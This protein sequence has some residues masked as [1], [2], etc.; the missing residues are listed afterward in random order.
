MWDSF[1]GPQAQGADCGIPEKLGSA[2]AAKPAVR[3]A[4]NFAAIWKDAPKAWD[5]MA[6]DWATPEAASA[7]YWRQ[8]AGLD[9]I[10]PQARGQGVH[11]RRCRPHFL[12]FHLRAVRERS[13]VGATLLDG[14]QVALELR[15][16]IA[17]SVLEDT[18]AGAEV[19]TLA[20]VLVGDDPASQVYV[21]NKQRACDKAGMRSQVLRL[22]STASAQQLLDTVGSLNDDRTIHGILVQLP[23]PK[24]IDPSTILDA[25]DPLKDVDA[26]HPHN[27]GLLMQ[28]RPRFLPCTPAG[29]QELLHRTRLS[30]VG[31][32]VVIVGRSDIVGKPLAAMLVQ[33]DAPCGPEAAN[34]TV[35]VCHSRTNDLKAITRS[36]DILVAAV[37]APHFITSEMV[38]PGAIVI[39][40][41]INRVDDRLVGDVDFPAVAKIASHITPVPGGVGPLTIAMLLANTL[42]A[43]RFQR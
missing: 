12:Q 39:D 26:F 20:A 35:T 34:A 22:P 9:Y 30:T 16:E 15:Q 29:I 28:G 40:V 4:G 37:G 32:H 2:P 23:L 43:A 3:C 27:V 5:I 6:D 31:R 21:R 38:R 17:L 24:G 13:T 42:R 11:T 36:A 19:P 18:A 7:S 10:R 14:K 1:A 41:G 25:I 33:K 8:S